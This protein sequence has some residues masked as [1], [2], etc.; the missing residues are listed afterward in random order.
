[1]HLAQMTHRN[2]SKEEQQ[3]QPQTH[4]ADTLA[5]FKQCCAGTLFDKEC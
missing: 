5:L 2:N 4:H 1:M 3:Q